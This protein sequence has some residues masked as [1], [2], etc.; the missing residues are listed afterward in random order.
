MDSDTWI[1]SSRHRRPLTY[2]E[3]IHV[4][5]IFN[6]SGLISSFNDV[7]VHDDDIIELQDGRWISSNV[8]DLYGELIMDR[9]RRDRVAP[10]ANSS[11]YP[12]VHV[13]SVNFWYLLQKKGYK[14]GS[15]KQLTLHVTY[16]LH[17]NIINVVL[18]NKIIDRHLF[19]RH[20]SSTDKS[21]E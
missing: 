9:A 13:F 4:Y 10:P 3:L 8:I 19:Q 2:A 14:G 11:L 18:T 5:D 12:D 15:L 21:S 6:R 7:E 20:Y 1:N 16:V 17:I